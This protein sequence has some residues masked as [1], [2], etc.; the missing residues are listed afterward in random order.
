MKVTMRRLLRGL[1]ITYHLQI[2]IAE[3]SSVTDVTL[4]LFLLYRIFPLPIICDPVVPVAEMYVLGKCF[5]FNSLSYVG[6]P[7]CARRLS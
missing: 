7:S 3:I 6:T 2:L 5:S 1:K 4:Y